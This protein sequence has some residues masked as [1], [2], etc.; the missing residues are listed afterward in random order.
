MASVN[1][2]VQT[3][4]QPVEKIPVAKSAPATEPAPTAVDV[5]GE[6]KP[7]WKKW[8]LW[9]IVVIVIAGIV[10]YLII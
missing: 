6:K 4:A 5:G 10:T 3:K 8:W 7:I 1:Q 9:A 2:A